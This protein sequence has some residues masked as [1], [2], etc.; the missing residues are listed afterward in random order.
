MIVDQINMTD[1][2]IP[3]VN[4]RIWAKRH[5]SMRPGDSIVSAADS[6]HIPSEKLRGSTWRCESAP[7][8]AVG[9]SVDSRLSFARSEFALI[10]VNWPSDRDTRRALTE[11]SELLDFP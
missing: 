5:L 6:V 7:W 2:L 9:A 4:R 3:T 10:K 11:Q 8:S 1:R